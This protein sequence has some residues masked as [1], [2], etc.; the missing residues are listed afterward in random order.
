MHHG[1]KRNVHSVE[2]F[3]TQSLLLSQP[4]SRDIKYNE[5]YIISSDEESQ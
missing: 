1:C 2:D 5:Q 4:V 3:I